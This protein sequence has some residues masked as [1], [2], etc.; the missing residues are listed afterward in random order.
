MMVL[1]R[2]QQK[3]MFAKGDFVRVRSGL[4]AGQVGKVLE[5]HKSKFG[6]KTWFTEIKTARGG[7]I[8]GLSTAFD[9]I[10]P[11]SQQK[12]V[13]ALREKLEK[14]SRRL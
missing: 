13:I 3:A 8:L 1:T 14:E 5:S 10:Q 11:T 4:N 9:K 6:D 2:K 7:N 12:K